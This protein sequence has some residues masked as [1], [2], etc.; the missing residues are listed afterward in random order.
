MTNQLSKGGCRGNSIEVDRIVMAIGGLFGDASLISYR[1]LAML[2][3]V[4]KLSFVTILCHFGHVIPNTSHQ[5]GRVISNIHV[6]LDISS[7][8]G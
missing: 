2:S 3:L 4:E 7:H 8:F 5:L 6:A 1:T